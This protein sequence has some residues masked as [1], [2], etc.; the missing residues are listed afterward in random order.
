MADTK[1][2][3]DIT[4]V[5]VS[6]KIIGEVIG[7]GE[8]QVRNLANEGIL[9]RNSHGKYLLLKSVKNFI[10][11]LKISKAGEKVDSDFDEAE[12][13]LNQ[14]KAKNEHWKA[15]ISEL[16]LA[17]FKGTMHRSEDVG[18]VITNMFASFKNKMLA[19]PATLA[20]KL[21]GKSRLEIQELLKKDIEQA[22]TE[23]AAYNP[24]DYYS[25]EYID[26]PENELIPDA[27]F[28]GDEDDEEKD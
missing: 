14:E 26:L 12:L 22:L 28:V 19:I 6:S 11:N 25:D 24:A 1:N 17:L 3:T 23:L 15:M 16:R 18:R 8:R 27:A 20:P 21:E 7:V 9:I 13:H 5:T 4:A 2:A 10:I